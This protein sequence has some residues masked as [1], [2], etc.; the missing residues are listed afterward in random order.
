MRSKMRLPMQE[1]RYLPPCFAKQNATA[2]AGAEVF[3]SLFCEAKCDCPCRSRGIYL[4]VLRSKMRLPMQEQRYLPPCFAKQNATAHAGAE[5]F[6]SLFCEAKCDC[7]HRS[8]G[9]YLFS[10]HNSN[11][12]SLVSGAHRP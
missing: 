1:Q 3:T 2:H 7:P 6:T 12:N 4:L 11:K 10:V 9:I 8:R 5:V